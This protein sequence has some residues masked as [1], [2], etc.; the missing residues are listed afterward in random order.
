MQRYTISNDTDFLSGRI[1]VK[2]LDGFNPRGTSSRRLVSLLIRPKLA[3]MRGAVEWRLIET[4][5]TWKRN[6][7]EAK[8]KGLNV[9]V[10]ES[11]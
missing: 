11:V 8:D 3:N 1:F 9:L 4:V 6:K 2:W 7:C 5:H 10:V